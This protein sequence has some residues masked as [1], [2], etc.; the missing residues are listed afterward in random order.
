MSRGLSK[1]IRHGIPWPS[2]RENISPSWSTRNPV[3]S[4]PSCFA[5]VHLHC[6]RLGWIGRLPG[7]VP[8]LG[9]DDSLSVQ[10]L[11]AHPVYQRICWISLLGL[12]SWKSSPLERE[13]ARRLSKTGLI[14]TTC[15]LLPIA[16]HGT[17]HNSISVWGQ[18]H[19]TPAA[20]TTLTVIAETY[21]VFSICP[22]LS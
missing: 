13:W 12:W 1:W 21:C 22:A 9:Q 18:S 16:L 7:L 19:Q 14:H 8:L 11:G 6:P 20:M 5:W 4:S 3:S 17:I 2:L 10:P 15:S